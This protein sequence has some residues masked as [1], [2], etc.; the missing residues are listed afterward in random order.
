MIDKWEDALKENPGL[1]RPTIKEIDVQWFKWLDW[2]PNSSLDLEG[3]KQMFSRL[4]R[5]KIQYRVTREFTG[6]P[7][8]KKEKNQ[9]V[10]LAQPIG[11]EPKS[12]W[13][14]LLGRPYRE[15]AKKGWE[16]RRNEA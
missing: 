4:D 6:Q 5:D 1:P 16:T 9:Y 7:V 3:F 15:R 8:K 14:E 13:V 11:E 2:V 12:E 10:S